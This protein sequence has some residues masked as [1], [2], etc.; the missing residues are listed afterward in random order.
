MAENPKK[1]SKTP[2]MLEISEMVDKIQRQLN[3]LSFGGKAVDSIM[4]RMANYEQLHSAAS[5]ANKAFQQ[6]SL[7][8]AYFENQSAVEILAQSRAEEMMAFN[9]EESNSLLKMA[10]QHGL[11]NSAVNIADIANKVAQTLSLASSNVVD[12]SVIAR[13]AQLSIPEAIAF[14]DTLLGM[15]EGQSAY[16][17]IMS[18]RE[19]LIQSKGGTSVYENMMS[20]VNLIRDSLEPYRSAFDAVRTSFEA[21]EMSKLVG[22]IQSQKAITNSVLLDYADVFKQVELLH[23]LESFKALTRLKNFPF[24]DMVRIDLDS[25]PDLEENI[26]ETIVEL[27]SEISDELSLVD[28]FNELSEERRT[29]LLGLYQVYYYSIILN[30]LF[31]LMWLQVFLDEKLDL[32]KN[33]FIFVEKSKEKLSYISN[34]YR[35]NPSAMID[36]F[37]VGGSLMLL[38]KILGW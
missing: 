9:F 30:C 32:T 19:S 5:I 36:N 2:S 13:Q 38:A 16:S 22:D 14:K 34:V 23:N 27:D 6:S 25:I 21:S 26:S 20:S 4:P 33:T 10:S 29:V 31:I 11:P 15:K 12:Q 1:D 37:V 24:E 35:P 28:D 17:S 8:P 18:A 7:M 3:P